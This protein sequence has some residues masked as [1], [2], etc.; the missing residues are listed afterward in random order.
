MKYFYFPFFHQTNK[1]C[2]NYF[3]HTKANGELGLTH[4]P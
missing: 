2:E 3:D 4:G 1:K